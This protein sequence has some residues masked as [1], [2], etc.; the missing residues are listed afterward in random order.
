MRPFN[1]DVQF[2][3]VDLNYMRFTTHYRLKCPMARI[4]H[5]KVPHVTLCI[6]SAQLNHMRLYCSVNSMIYYKPNTGTTVAIL[7]VISHWLNVRILDVLPY[8]FIFLLI[9]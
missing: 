4:R 5:K 6:R 8:F 1:T 7:L 9:S 2:Q 3:T